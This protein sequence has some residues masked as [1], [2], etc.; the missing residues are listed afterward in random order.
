MSE[1]TYADGILRQRWDDITRT[2][3][4]WDAA[5]QQVE[6][7]PYTAEEN[8]LADEAAATEAEESN[9][10]SMEAQAVAALA[11]LQ[12][13][14]DTPLGELTQAQVAQQVKDNARIL[15]RLI[16]LMTSQYDATD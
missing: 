15:K 1:E 12:T 9:K 3:T 8:A 11:D 5:G 14:I 2:Y 13:Y 6:S 4:E 10:S 7:R 16:R